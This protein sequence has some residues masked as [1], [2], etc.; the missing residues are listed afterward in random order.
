M[1]MKIVVMSDTHLDRVTDGFESICAEYCEGADMVI[2][3]GDWSRSTVLDYLEQYP[4]EAVSGNMDDCAIRD[5]LPAKKVLQVK[6]FRLGIIHGWGSPV[7]MRHR[8]YDEFRSVDAILFGHT[9]QAVTAEEMGIR[10]FN[11]GS[12]TMGR[13]ELPRSL[14]ILSIEDRIRWEIIPL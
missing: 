5:R 11:P 1:P 6:G 10:W 7:G 4:L 2:H 13:G 9:H 14:G 12:V 3:L 8:L